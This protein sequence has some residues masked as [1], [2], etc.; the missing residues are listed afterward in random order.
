MT[1]LLE[2][3]DLKVH[4][5]MGHGRAVRALDGVS[6]AVLSGETLSLVGESGSGK[7]TLGR[8]LL[9]LETPTAGRI[10]AFG[11][12]ITD[13]PERRLR[14]G[15]R[16]RAAM[17]FQ[18]AHSLN[19]RMSVAEAV[20]EPLAVQ[21]MAPAERHSRVEALLRRVGLDPAT[22]NRRP[23]AFSGGQL[24]RVG[25]AR[26]LALDPAVVVADEAVSA[27]DVSVQAGIINLFMELQAEHG[28]AW[29]FIAHDLKV[30][31]LIS[32]RVAV[33]YLGR[34]VELAPTKSLFGQ[35]RHPYTR[36]LLAA[37]P[38]PNPRRPM[39]LPTLRG[40]PPSPIAPPPGCTFHPRC[41]EAVPTCT[42]TVPALRTDAAGH[43]V[44]CHLVSIEEAT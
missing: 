13:L 29:L 41:P 9:R 42:A 15:L 28:I 17:V 19:P 5:S 10:R 4:F 37:A 23:H 18:D 7:S 32:H 44:A 20:A 36:A 6:L 21:G 43:A 39:Q 33:M 12:D 35:P 31:E 8:A 22:Q 25:I 11:E 38:V 34:I 27:L 1:P 30:V 26:A 3:I 16:R 14:A 2:A 24:Q 40:E